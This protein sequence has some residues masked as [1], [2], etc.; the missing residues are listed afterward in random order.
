M[1]NSDWCVAVFKC[2][3][4]NIRNVLVDFY[5]FMKDLE[6][7]NFLIGDRVENEIV[8]SFRVLAAEKTREIV[9][10]KMNY[11]LGILLPDNFEVDPDSQSPLN[12][13]VVW[14]T[15]GAR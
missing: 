6:E 14:G 1:T 5:G 8:A 7:L 9:R 10:R 13:Y 12:K 15:E 11:K 2:S 3:K 4:E